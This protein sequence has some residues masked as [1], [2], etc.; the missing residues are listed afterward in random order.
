MKYA[1][2]LG[3]GMSDRPMPE[4]D[5]ATPLMRARTPNLDRIVSQGVGGWSR[6]TP[7]GFEPGSDV[8]N[9]GVLGY[10][11]R[12]G[13][14]GRSPLEAAALGI[15]LQPTDVAFRCNL[16]TLRND[17]SVMDD[18]SAGHITNEEA[19]SIIATLQQELG[20]EQWTF[21]PGVSYRHALIWH[22]GSEA[23]SAT[24]PH[25]IHDQQVADYQPKGEA[26]DAVRALMQAAEPI[27]R[28]HPVNQ[29]RIGRGEKPANA[30][31][32]WG[33][34]R[35]PQLESF[36]SL[37]GLSGAMITAVD[38]M[39]GIAAN[40]GFENIH[41]DGAT[42][43]IDTNY[44]GKAQAALAAL[45]RHDLVFVH[46]ESPDESGHAGRLDYK[47]QAI[48][49]FDAKV[50]GPVLDGLEAM[51]QY[52]VVSLPDHPTPVATRTHNMDPV[53]FAMCGTGIAPD[54]NQAYD[55]HLLQ[56]GSLTF[57]PGMGMMARFL[58]K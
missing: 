31:W 17:L 34:G 22:H 11:V 58:S 51:G 24:P 5:G 16:V 25:D 43:W 26:A 38:L 35:R 2:L 9:L 4:L 23:L 28:D 47:I 39:R 45:A 42:G 40:I 7:D 10:D 33:H 14:T 54:S 46:V 13:Y 29:A 19:A 57:N 48:E 12:T 27:L 56:S 30:I 32:L 55:E 49:D 1:I 3:D 41:V 6:N 36:R 8:A 21:H 37:Y 44:A 18:F 53:P 15:D 20:S 52:R 50:V